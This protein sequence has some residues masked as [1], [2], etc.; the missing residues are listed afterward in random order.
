[1]SA[2]EASIMAIS[3]CMADVYMMCRAGLS[4]GVE[5][6]Y[7]ILCPDLALLNLQKVLVS[8]GHAGVG[9]IHISC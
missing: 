6:I 1:M 8:V 4:V 2:Y 9:L 7:F 3:N 5:Y